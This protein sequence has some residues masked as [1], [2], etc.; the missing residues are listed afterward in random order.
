MEALSSG[1]GVFNFS[2]GIKTLNNPCAAMERF[3]GAT[4]GLSIAAP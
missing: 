1:L 2:S 3:A 4:G